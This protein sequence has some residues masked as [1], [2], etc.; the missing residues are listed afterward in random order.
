MSDQ[1]ARPL[2]ITHD[3]ELI[4]AC[5]AADRRV[6]ALLAEAERRAE[7]AARAVAPPA[8]AARVEKGEE[9]AA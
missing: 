3:R 6:F 1:P 8:P 4:A 9:A 2:I 7:H 5:D